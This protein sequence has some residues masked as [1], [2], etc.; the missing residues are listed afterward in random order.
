MAGIGNSNGIRYSK[1]KQINASNVSQL[2]VAWTYDAADGPGSLETNPIIVNGILYANTP[3]H[4]V[5]A[6][7]AATGQQL[8]LFDSGLVGRGPNRGVS[9]WGSGSDQRIF[10]SVQRYLYALDAKTGKPIPSF[11]SNGRIDLHENLR[12][13]PEHAGKPRCG[14]QGSVDHRQP[15]GGSDT[16]VPRRHS[17]LRRAQR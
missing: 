8:W 4:K 6:L 15:H 2:Q 13:D 17:R 14:L 9:Y 10:A 11:G 16:G 7:N 3:T 1:L 12:G 5:F